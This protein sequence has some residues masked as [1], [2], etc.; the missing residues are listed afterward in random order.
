MVKFSDIPKLFYKKMPKSKP[1]FC[2][3]HKNQ[4]YKVAVIEDLS[5]GI[6]DVWKDYFKMVITY[7]I[8]KKYTLFYSEV[9]ESNLYEGDDQIGDLILPAVR[10]AF[11]KVY[12]NPPS[13]FTSRESN[14]RLELFRLLF[15]IDEFLDYLAFQIINC[16]GVLKEFTYLD[17][18]VETLT[19]IVDNWISKLVKQVLETEDIKVDIRDMKIKRMV[20]D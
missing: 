15:D 8:E 7:V 20:N 4:E 13:I 16:K 1:K 9:Y 17:R 11:G 10:R 2:E 19:L 3:I 14:D 6:P 12:V 18:T 5:A